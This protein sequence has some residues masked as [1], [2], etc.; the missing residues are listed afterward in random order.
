MHSLLPG[1]GLYIIT[2]SHN[3]YASPVMYVRTI[4]KGAV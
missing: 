2:H 1:S 3:S 4:K